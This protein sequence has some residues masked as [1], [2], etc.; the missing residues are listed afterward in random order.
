[1]DFL[2]ARWAL[3]E[4]Q[5]VEVM[6]FDQD[7]TLRR[8]WRLEDVAEFYMVTH[9]GTGPGFKVNPSAPLDQMHL[10]T[11]L[12][13]T[14]WQRR[15]NWRLD[16][17]YIYARDT[18]HTAFINPTMNHGS[19]AVRGFGYSTLEA[20]LSAYVKALEVLRET[21]TETRTVMLS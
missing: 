9:G 12:E 13:E 8:I 2:V 7:R 1:M 3:L 20:L 17:G 15:W 16:S 5:Q 11:A 4:D 6:G 21:N 18:P 14:L 10:R 19:P